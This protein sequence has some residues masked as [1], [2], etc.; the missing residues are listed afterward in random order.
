MDTPDLPVEDEAELVRRLGAD[1]VRR[2]RREHLVDAT[3]T[4]I[5]TSVG[6]L[7]LVATDEGLLRVAFETEG[8]REVL[9]RISAVVGPRIMRDDAGMAGFAAAVQAA[10]EGA[11]PP[12]GVPLDLGRC[13]GFRREVLD[14]LRTIPPG[15][16]RSYA[17]VARA[18]GRPRAVRAVGTACATNPLPLVIP[19]HRVVRSDGAVGGYLGGP[20]VK[21]RLLASER[22]AA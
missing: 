14:L 20:E 8:H 2:A 7:L 11:S 18:L 17:E 4:R 1:L 9:A 13:T 22:S 6:K 21:R 19:C 12:S 16:T 3:V 5:D 15:Q 10:L